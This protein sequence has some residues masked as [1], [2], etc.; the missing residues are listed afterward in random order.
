MLGGDVAQ[1]GTRNDLKADLDEVSVF[2]GMI[3]PLYGEHE[4]RLSELFREFVSRSSLLGSIIFCADKVDEVLTSLFLE[5]MGRVAEVSNKQCITSS[6]MERVEFTGRFEYT[7]V[8]MIHFLDMT[9]NIPGVRLPFLYLINCA[10]IEAH[11]K[12]FE[13][14][15]WFPW[16]EKYLSLHSL[17]G[18]Y[19]WHNPY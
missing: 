3:A 17:P 16:W 9:N 1:D 15:E 6:D 19:F 5:E 7:D 10:C 13:R 18:G 4:R 12:R 11:K 8:V 14:E 2:D